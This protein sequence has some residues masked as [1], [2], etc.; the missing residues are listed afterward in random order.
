M[1]CDECFRQQQLQ[2]EHQRFVYE[3]GAEIYVKL[4]SYLFF[5]AFTIFNSVL[6]YHFE[7]CLQLTAN[8][9]SLLPFDFFNE[10]KILR[11]TS[12]YQ[13]YHVNYRKL[14]LFHYFFCRRVIKMTNLSK[15]VVI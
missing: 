11:L 7:L 9:G 10:I 14:F 13:I 3:N 12:S 6:F 1:F 8:S 5:I 2:V 15:Q 4:V